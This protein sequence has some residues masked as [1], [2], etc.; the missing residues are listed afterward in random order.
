MLQII[1]AKCCWGHCRNILQVWHSCSP[2]KC[3]TNLEQLQW[4]EELHWKKYRGH[5]RNILQILPSVTQTIGQLHWKKAKVVNEKNVIVVLQPSWQIL[6]K[7]VK[8]IWRRNWRVTPRYFWTTTL[9]KKLPHLYPH[10]LAPTIYLQRC[11]VPV[12]LRRRA[13]KPRQD[14]GGRDVDL[15]LQSLQEPAVGKPSCSASRRWE[16]QEVTLR[17]T[18]GLCF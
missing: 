3:D 6:Q 1:S 8:E 17:V 9:Q 11:L 16:C 12:K 5:R 2:T 4:S 15:L 14:P 7:Q 13:Q 18:W 10:F